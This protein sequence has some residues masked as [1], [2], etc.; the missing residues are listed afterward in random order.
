MPTPRTLDIEGIEPF[1]TIGLSNDACAEILRQAEL[2][3][4]SLH[5]A[6]GC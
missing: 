4:G 6:L 1:A 3:L 2:Q 5:D